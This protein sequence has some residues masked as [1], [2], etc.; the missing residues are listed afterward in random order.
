MVAEKVDGL[1]VCCVLGQ[2]EELHVLIQCQLFRLIDI[3]HHAVL[4]SFALRLVLPFLEYLIKES[5]A[6]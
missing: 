2:D 6:F 3:A 1:L 5:R 4:L